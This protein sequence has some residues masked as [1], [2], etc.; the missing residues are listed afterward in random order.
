MFGACPFTHPTNALVQDAARVLLQ[1]ASMEPAA[2]AWQD[3]ID[4]VLFVAIA[5]QRVR[6]LVVSKRT[7][8]DQLAGVATVGARGPLRYRDYT[9]GEGG[10]RTVRDCSC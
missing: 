2:Q 8:L 3:R 1:L 4:R 6:T 9:T 7:S 10:Q 5:S